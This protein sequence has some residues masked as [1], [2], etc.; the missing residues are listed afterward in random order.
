MSIPDQMPPR[1]FQLN[2][3]VGTPLTHAPRLVSATV[4]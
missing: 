4:N 3:A 1:R 2:E